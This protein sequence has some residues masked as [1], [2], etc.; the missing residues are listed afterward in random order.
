MYGSSLIRAPSTSPGNG[1]GTFQNL[2][3]QPLNHRYRFLK[4]LGQ[5]GF[6]QTFLAVDERNDSHPCV[7]KQLFL[8]QNLT[9]QQTTSERFHQ[10]VKR[11][12]EL[13]EQ[14]LLVLVKPTGCWMK[15]IGSSV[16]EE[17]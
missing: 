7:V 1:S 17:M 15:P 12:V 2:F 11:L 4:H 6:G 8:Q 16:W 10:E 14:W 13:G 5:G 9:H 3:S